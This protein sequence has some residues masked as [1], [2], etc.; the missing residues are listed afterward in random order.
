MTPSLKVLCVDDEPSI[1]DAFKRQLRGKFELDIAVGGKTGLQLVAERGPYAVV[2]SDMRMPMMDGIEFLKAVQKISPDSVRIM[3]TGND[4]KKNAARAVNEGHI[5]RFLTKPCSLED[6]TKALS[7]A[8]T[9]YLLLAAEKDLLQNTL[10]GSVKLLTDI[11]SLLDPASFGETMKLRA[12]IRNIV[13]ELGIANAW[14]IE[15]GAM[16]SNIGFITVPS[17]VTSRFRKGR[18]LQAD[19]RSLIEKVPS[20]GYSLIN[21]IPRLGGVAKIVLYQHK[22]F[23]GSG[24]PS[25]NVKGENIPIGSRILKILKDLS[26][27]ESAGTPKIPALEKIQGKCGWYDGNI[28]K[29]IVKVLGSID[30]SPSSNAETKIYEVTSHQLLIGQ[31]LLSDVETIDGVLLI[32]GGAMITETLFERLTNYS[33]FIGIKE[34]IHVDCLIPAETE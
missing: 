29:I 28:L 17:F 19:E 20:I 26:Q 27:Y 9:Q 22:H 33:R 23:D 12:P 4:D 18:L 21:N 30:T 2:V 31:T 24:H 13:K 7:D 5:Y 6:L 14:D 1:L 10:S 34:P 25:D 15:L 32:P 8:A 3:L 11:L 16:L